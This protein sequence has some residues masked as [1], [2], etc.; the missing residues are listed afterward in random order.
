MRG[1]RVLVS[2]SPRIRLPVLGS[3]TLAGAGTRVP[4]RWPTYLRV[5]ITAVC[6]LA[7][8]FCHREGDPA[9]PGRERGLATE[10]WIALLGGA[11]DAGVRK[12]KFLGGEPLLRGDL[13]EIVRALRERD[14]SLDL[15]VITSGAVP[16]ARIDALFAAG[17]SRCNVSIHGFG[18]EAF[19]ARTRST[20]RAWW[21]RNAF[22]EAVIDHGRALKTNYVYTGPADDADLAAFLDFAARRSL[23]VNVL[24]DLTRDDLDA[25]ALERVVVSMRGTPRERWI[26]EDPHS[27]PATRLGFADGLTV[28]LKHARLGGE[29]PWTSCSTCTVRAHCK[30]G[31]HALRVTHTGSLRPCMDRPDLSTALA[32]PDGRVEREAARTSMDAFIRA[33]AV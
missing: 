32:G 13:P 16:A 18:R 1:G 27:L 20:E 8:S 4:R 24:D 10:D 33:I 7:C 31:I 26:E 29:M 15:S 14:A 21:Q 17:L 23:L 11:V 19:I 2:M 25:A 3:S 12:V 9:V 5:V 28:E 30:E 22:L 6:P